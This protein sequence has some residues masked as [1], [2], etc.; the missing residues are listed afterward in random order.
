MG[1]L[2]RTGEMTTRTSMVEVEAGGWWLVA[3]VGD[4][5][6]LVCLEVRERERV[7]MCEREED[8]VTCSCSL[9][10]SLGLE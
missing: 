3:V 4:M 10:Y 6:I 7:C 5:G 1:T 8:A 9:I 2:A